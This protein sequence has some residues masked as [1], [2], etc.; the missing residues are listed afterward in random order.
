MYFKAKMSQIYQSSLE[1]MDKQIY[2][3]H[4]IDFLGVTLDSALS[5]QGHIT[6][7]ITKLNSACFA[8]RSLKLFLT[9]E[10]LRIVYFAYVH[11]IIMYGLSFGGNAVNTKNVFMTQKGIIGVIMNVNPKISCRGLYRC[12]ALLFSV[13]VFFIV[14]GSKKCIQICN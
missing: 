3:T 12:L 9:I 5:W 10:D 4:C 13:H 7:V 8:I 11:S 6:K 14:V 2:S 1:F